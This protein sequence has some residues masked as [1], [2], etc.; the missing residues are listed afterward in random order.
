[1]QSGG[2][3]KC[4]DLEGTGCHQ[5][6]AKNTFLRMRTNGFGFGLKTEL[7]FLRDQIFTFDDTEPVLEVAMT[8]MEFGTH[9]TRNCFE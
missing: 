6:R 2:L 5:T 1:V 8:T 4:L 7:T 3:G 9:K